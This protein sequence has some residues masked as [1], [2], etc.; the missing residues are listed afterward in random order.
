MSGIARLYRT[1]PGRHATLA[2]CSG[3]RSAP[4]AP[5]IAFDAYTNPGTRIA[6]LRGIRHRQSSIRS[7]V[8]VIAQMSS[9]TRAT[10]RPSRC[11]SARSW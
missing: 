5:T 1:I 7:N 3:L 2:T 9:T 4:I 11:S 8:V 10:H 6:P